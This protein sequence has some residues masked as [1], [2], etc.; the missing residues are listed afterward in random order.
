MVVIRDKTIVILMLD[1]IQLNIVILDKIKNKYKIDNKK[2][3]KIIAKVR[4]VFDDKLMVMKMHLYQ[5]H[6]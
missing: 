5:T 3:I 4:Y 2:Y 6:L 1:K